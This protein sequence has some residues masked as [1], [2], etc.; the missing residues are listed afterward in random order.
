MAETKNTSY[1]REYGGRLLS[2]G[3]SI[4]PIKQGFK[5][6]KGLSGWEQI[7]ATEKHLNKWLAN[8]FA[9]G[10]TGV[11]TKYTPA[12]DVDVQDTDIVKLL[13]AWCEE[14]IGPTVQRV[15]LAPK[16]LLA[17]RTEE[18]FTKIA[19]KTYEDM[20]G[21]THRVEI[22]GDGQ[23]F[24]A[25]AVHPD[26]GEPYHWITDDSL[27]DVA[28]DDLPVITADQAQALVDYF[29]SIIPDDWDVVEQGQ[30]G[31]TIDY[32]LSE[33][34]RVLANSKPKAD[35]STK[36]LKIALE[37]VDSDDYNQWVKVGMALHHQYDGDVV[38]FEIWDGWSQTSSK[39][40]PHEMEAKW[41]TFKADLTKQDPIAAASILRL[42]RLADEQ[43]E[44]ELEHFIKRYIYVEKG[45]QVYDIQKPA[46]DALSRLHEFKNATA[47]I[48]HEV[49]APTQKEPDKVK[50][51]P[52]HAS[53]L[54][55]PDRKTARGEKYNPDEKRIF[56]EHGMTWINSYRMP[57]H[58][59]TQSRDN[60]QIFFD[61]M[62]YLLPK[63]WNGNG[64][65]TGLLST[66]S[67]PVSAAK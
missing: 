1:L 32:S 4:I 27:A 30:T 31:K 50:L 7:N 44:C 20:F 63:K 5:F 38:G 52:V 24:V 46:N 51:A 41:K 54:V 29:E 25:F 17:Y 11:L 15:G 13:V 16:V 59:A 48:R 55:H 21:L 66:S 8:G 19:S 53:W 22:L 49:P 14:H 40:N 43:D 65:L 2:L 23:Q 34:E 9:E 10:G 33:T 6:P 45:D 62:D 36:R 57:E 64:L 60:A 26:T 61:H 37:S 39:Y 42:A 58:Q 56:K 12:V 35:V 67:S 18:P 28:H 3:Y 47:N